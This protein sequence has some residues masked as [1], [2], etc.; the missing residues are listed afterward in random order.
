MM[1][2][3]FFLFFIKINSNQDNSEMNNGQRNSY[4]TMAQVRNNF[5]DLP[6]KI[7]DK[8]PSKPTE[9]LHDLSNEKGGFIN[10]MNIYGCNLNNKMISAT[11]C[12]LLLY[13]CSFI[14]LYSQMDP[15]AISLSFGDTNL[16]HDSIIDQCSFYNCS[17]SN[18]GC[19]K[20][21]TD[22]FL[23]RINIT[24]SLFINNTCSLSGGAISFSGG[25]GKIE[26]C[27][28]I[29]NFAIKD[30]SAISFIIQKFETVDS[31]ISLQKNIFELHENNSVSLFNFNVLKNPFVIFTYNTLNITDTNK[32]FVLFSISKYVKI[33]FEYFFFTNNELH[34]NVNPFYLENF[35]FHISFNKVFNMDNSTKIPTFSNGRLPDVLYTNNNCNSTKL[36][37]YINNEVRTVYV[38]ILVTKFSGYHETSRDGGAIFLQDCDVHLVNSNLDDCSASNGG[39]G[40]IYIKNKIDVDNK[41]LFKNL[42]ISNCKAVFGG[43]LYIYSKYKSS[44]FLI[45]SCSFLS[46][47]IIITE[48]PYIKYRGGSAIYLTIYN[49]KVNDC[50]FKSR[51]GKGGMIK[52]TEEYDD[53]DESGIILL[54]QM[55][56]N[57]I[58]FDSCDFINEKKSIEF[59]GVQ[60][61]ILKTQK[62]NG[63]KTGQMFIND[64]KRIHLQSCYFE[65]EQNLI[66]RKWNYNLRQNMVLLSSISLSSL[67]GLTFLVFLL[68]KKKIFVKYD[69]S[70]I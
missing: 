30:G 34:T 51:D 61:I 57:I 12:R 25:Q 49:G 62:W 32:N 9:Y 33:N 4:E 8:C 27:S 55:N 26:N 65:N 58:E 44:D 52:V 59:E 7:I 37:R 14:S 46:N 11:N 16:G 20:Y 15:G 40:A 35:Q 66:L 38:L 23:S 54:K 6:K 50:I 69:I 5:T 28:F 68:I 63:R 41:I 42:T 53:D 60:N 39:G 48:N 13:G 67:F 29:N 47:E 3:F 21:Y 24:N 70:N 43:A 64:K 45:Q 31:I 19:I 56:D 17:G 22:Y 18:G 2:I 1:K 36:C 10:K